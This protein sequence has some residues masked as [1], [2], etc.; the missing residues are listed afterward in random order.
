MSVETA[1][2]PILLD[3]DMSVEAYDLD[4]D[5]TSEEYDLDVATQIQNITIEGHGFPDGGNPGDLIIKRSSADY[6]VEWVAPATSAEADNTRPIT[7]GAV[8]TEIGN[9][10]A[11]LATI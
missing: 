11:L 1:L 5:Q 2:E 8:Y 10:N 6:D 7:A 4:V 3:V 9:I